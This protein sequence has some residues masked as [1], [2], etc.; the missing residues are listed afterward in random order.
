MGPY[1]SSSGDGS[2]TRFVKREKHARVPQ[3]HIEDG[4]KL[5]FW[6]SGQRTSYKNNSLEPARIQA[7]ESVKGWGT[8]VLATGCSVGLYFLSATHSRGLRDQDPGRG[9]VPT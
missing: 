8:P 7:L 3:K 1:E 9:A 2:A 6:V 4:F 5:G